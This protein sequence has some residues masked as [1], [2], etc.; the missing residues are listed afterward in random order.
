MAAHS[1]R[2]DR[3]K[4]VEAAPDDWSLLDPSGQPF[5]RIY[6][7]TGG[8]NEA[9]WLP[10]EEIVSFLRQAPHMADIVPGAELDFDKPF[11]LS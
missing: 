7:V 2:K 3:R 1:V 11:L 8:P 9:R 6:K 10:H 5:A 4:W